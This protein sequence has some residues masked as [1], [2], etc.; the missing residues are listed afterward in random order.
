MF[1]LQ[2]IPSRNGRIQALLLVQMS[3]QSPY[4]L[5]DN[6]LEKP[7][8]TCSSPHYHLQLS[9]FLKIQFVPVTF[10]PE[11]FGTN[12]HTSCLANCSSSSLHDSVQNSSSKASYTSLGSVREETR[13]F[14]TISL[15]L[16]C[17]F[18]VTLS[19]SK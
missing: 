3:H 6:I 11:V 5:S 17:S 7:V 19:A 10:T 1:N 2:A 14:F 13:E 4:L 8:W 12:S 9:F 15:K 18:L 16:I